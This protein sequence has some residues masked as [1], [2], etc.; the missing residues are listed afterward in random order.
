[1]PLL[2]RVKKARDVYLLSSVGEYDVLAGDRFAQLKKLLSSLDAFC[3]Q[4]PST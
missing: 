4:E 1:V 3:D 2:D